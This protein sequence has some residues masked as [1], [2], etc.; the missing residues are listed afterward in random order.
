MARAVRQRRRRRNW[1]A[2]SAIRVDHVSLSL[3]PWKVR[4]MGFTFVVFRSYRALH[5]SEKTKRGKSAALVVGRLYAERM[6]ASLNAMV[7]AIGPE[8]MKVSMRRRVHRLKS[9]KQ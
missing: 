1:S 5:P 2:P 4:R 6:A 7:S 8:R 9:S 3:G